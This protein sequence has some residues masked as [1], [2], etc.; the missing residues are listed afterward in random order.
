MVKNVFKIDGMYCPMC[1]SHVNDAIRAA[2]PG[3]KV[4]SDHASGVCEVLS[5][6]GID[7][8]KAAEA[9]GKTGYKVI[10]SSSGPYEKKSFFKRLFK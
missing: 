8:E 10:S 7:P 9:L 3:V 2:F 4:K 6:N 1:E 5:E